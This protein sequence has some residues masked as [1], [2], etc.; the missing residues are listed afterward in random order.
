MDWKVK[1]GGRKSGQEARSMWEGDG[2]DSECR[3]GKSM[4]KHLRAGAYTSR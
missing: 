2:R 3:E 4:K 1:T